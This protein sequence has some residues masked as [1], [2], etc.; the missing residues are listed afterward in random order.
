MAYRVGLYNK[1]GCPLE[2]QDRFAEGPQF[3]RL[4]HK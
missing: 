4:A 3:L 1:N 2:V